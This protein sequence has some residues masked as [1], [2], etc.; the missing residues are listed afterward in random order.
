VGQFEQFLQK[1]QVSLPFFFLY[2]ILFFSLHKRRTVHRNLIA[3]L[4]DFLVAD[5]GNGVAEWIDGLVDVWI[6]G[7]QAHRRL[8]VDG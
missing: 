4:G 8:K 1:C 2:F 7:R 5:D 3:E 6:S